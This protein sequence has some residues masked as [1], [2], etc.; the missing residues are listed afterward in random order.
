MK[1]IW[2]H[3]WDLTPKEAV[4]LQRELAGRIVCQDRWRNYDTVAGIDVGIRGDTARAAVVV[5]K[6]PELVEIERA[7]IDAPVRFPYVPGLLSFREAPAIL[8]AL[9]LLQHT[10]DV[11]MFDGQGYAHPRRMGIASHVGLLL[12]WPTV[13]CA[14]SRLCGR[15][16]EPGLERGSSAPLMD[17]DEVIGTVLRTRSG[18]RPVY[19]SVGHAVSLEGAVAL[20]LACGRRY[21]LPEPT[22]QA[23]QV[24][25]VEGRTP[26]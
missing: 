5:L 1:P 14:K 24:A 4:A 23:H 17:G 19:V 20:V 6:L 16:E 10:P 18:V 8:Q 25:S 3:R 2:E 26:D 7:V 9:A 12:D 11:L 22:R 15:A 21:R 13:G